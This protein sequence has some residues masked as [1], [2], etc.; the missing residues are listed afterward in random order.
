MS[1]ESP[2]PM[3]VLIRICWT[4]LH[5]DYGN[6][7]SLYHLLVG[8]L[9]AQSCLKR[10]ASYKIM[11]SLASLSAKPE[12]IV[13]HIRRQW[14][15]CHMWSLLTGFAKS[16]L[17]FPDYLSS[18]HL[19]LMSTLKQFITTRLL[20]NNDYQLTLTGMPSPNAN[21]LWTNSWNRSPRFDIQF[22]EWQISSTLPDMFG[23]SSA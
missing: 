9:I 19:V 14:P 10:A 4:L 8:I 7:N 2:I 22:E 17:S 16:V 21:N 11:A 6:I 23:M 1:H 12:V 20:W 5:L 13:W 18:E 3:F 15:L